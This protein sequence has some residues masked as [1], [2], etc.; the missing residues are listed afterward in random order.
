[1]KRA[2]TIKQNKGK[3]AEIQKKEFERKQALIE[4]TFQE[5]RAA[6]IHEVNREIKMRNSM[7]E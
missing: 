1:L 7:Q 6:R 2:A 5:Q 3:K 4:K